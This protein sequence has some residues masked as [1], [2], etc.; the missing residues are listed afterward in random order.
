MIKKKSIKMRLV[1]FI[2]QQI[3]QIFYESIKE[4][5]LKTKSELLSAMNK[6]IQLN[7]SDKPLKKVITG[8]WNKEGLLSTFICDECSYG[9]R[10]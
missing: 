4:N 5:S 1:E 6:F 8:D 10:G 9:R 3:L 2:D 7:S